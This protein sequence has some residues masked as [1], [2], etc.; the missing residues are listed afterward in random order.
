MLPV[1]SSSVAAV[2]FVL[3][4]LTPSIEPSSANEDLFDPKPLSPDTRFFVKKESIE[5]FLLLFI[6][7]LSVVAE[8]DALS[9]TEEVPECVDKKF[10]TLPF[11]EES[12]GFSF[13]AAVTPDDA[14]CN[15]LLGIYRCGRLVLKPVMCR[16]QP[17]QYFDITFS[18]CL[19]L[20]EP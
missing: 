13:F 17:G 10:L 8:E 19:G 15:F 1:V 16:L 9:W 3:E 20:L 18:P 7:L 2:L 4:P 12:L 5:A 14:T 6:P 11:S